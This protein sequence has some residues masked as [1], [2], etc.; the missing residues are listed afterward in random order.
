MKLSRWA[1]LVI[2][3]PILATAGCDSFKQALT[4][5]S[6]TVARAAGKELKVDDAAQMLAAQ[7][8][9]PADPKIVRTLAELWVDYTL[10]ATAVAEDSTLAVID[11]DQLIK[12]QREGLLIRKLFEGQVHVDTAFTD[13]Q[14]DQ[15]WATEGPGSE[16]RARHILFRMPE[17]AT[18]AQRDSVK[19]LAESI[20][21]R[22]AG[23]EDFAGLAK[24]YS[25]D[26]SA[27]QGGDLG[28]FGRGK[29]VPAFEEAAFKLAPGQISPVVESPFGYHVIKV[30]EKRQQPLGDHRA[31]FRQY[32]VQHSQQD[33][34]QKYVDGL[35]ASNQLKVDSGAVK[36]VKELAALPDLKNVSGASRELATYKGGELTAG[37]FA[38]A[39]ADASAQ[40]REGLAQQA[41]DEQINGIVKRIATQELLL[42][43]AEAHHVTVPAAELNNL[44]TQAKDAV[45]QLVQMTGLASHRIPKGDAGDAAIQAE[46]RDLI[47][48]VITGQRQLPPLGPLGR[49]LQKHYDADVYA[50]SFAKVAEKMKSIRATQPQVAPPAGM[51]GQQVPQGG[52]PMP[53]QGMPQQGPPQGP[54]PAG[55]QPQAQ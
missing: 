18:P 33:A 12:P 14:V 40:D 34:E 11:Y 6:N 30:E 21:V 28:F 4:S 5:H 53:P 13:A 32:L 51:P 43:E 50:A 35:Q 20:R 46:V 17:G 3:A 45:R 8:Q 41:T 25:A 37:E 26:G 36:I 7:P 16:V 2:A 10:L 49:A 48:G 1:P 47:N 27:Q 29:M 55:T 22:A 9:I 31:E 23:G 24:Q 44:R 54:P 19:K 38:D 42:H 15:R 52:Q 39:L